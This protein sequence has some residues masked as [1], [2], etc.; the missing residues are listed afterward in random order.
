[1]GTRSDII[2]EYSNGKFHRIYC[3]WDGYL[4]HN[5]RILFDHYTTQ[6]K[7]EALV[8]LG[9]ISSLK[10]EIGVK[11]P[12]ENPHRRWIGTGTKDNP[13]YAAFEAKYGSMCNVYGRDRGEKD[14]EATV[15][16]TLQ[17]VWPGED[18]W[19][20]FTYVWR[21]EPGKWFV[22]SADDGTQALVDLGDALLGKVDVGAV[23][24]VPFAGIVLGKH[25]KMPLVD[26]TPLDVIAKGK[27]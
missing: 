9:D 2:V 14:T 24:K 23:S 17:A 10:A 13:K 15:G 19:T 22:C 12:F 20:E 6:V 27:T 21:K 25:P 11:H 7:C 3:H 16:D 1:M 26:T 18:T 4:G 5:G 8:A